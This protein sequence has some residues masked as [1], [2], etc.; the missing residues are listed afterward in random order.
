MVVRDTYRL[1]GR[2][3]GRRV[4]IPESVI[5]ILKRWLRGRRPAQYLLP[6]ELRSYDRAEYRWTTACK[7][8]GLLDADALERGEREAAFSIH[9]LRHNYGVTLARAGLSLLEI[10]ALMG[11]RNEATTRRYA[12]FR[13][14]GTD[15]RRFARLVDSAA[16]PDRARRKKGGE[17]PLRPQA[18]SRERRGAARRGS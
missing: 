11:H 5:P 12:R 17:A 9:S 10:G 6:D 14:K 4:P 8:A 7:A 13:P 1:K 15:L 3:A 16:R 2:R 18:A